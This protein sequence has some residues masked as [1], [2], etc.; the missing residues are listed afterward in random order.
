M[1]FR[2]AP[3]HPILAP[4]FWR[5]AAQAIVALWKAGRKRGLCNRWL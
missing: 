1:G 3:S 2:A 4:G 5:V